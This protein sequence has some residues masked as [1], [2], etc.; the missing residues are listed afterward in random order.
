MII[1]CCSMQKEDIIENTIVKCDE[2]MILYARG[3]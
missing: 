1:L 2:F 3:R